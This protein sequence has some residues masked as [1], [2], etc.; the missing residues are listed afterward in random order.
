M[1]GAPKGWAPDVVRCRR[2]GCAVEFTQKTPRHAYC[3]ERCRWQHKDARDPERKAR[4]RERCAEWYERK[5][6]ATAQR[7]TEQPWLVGPPPFGEHLPGGAFSVSF[8]PP[9]RWPLDLRNAR[10]LH[11][12]MTTLTAIPHHETMPMFTLIPINGTR[13]KWGVWVADEGVAR[14]LAGRSWPGQVADQSVLIQCGPLVRFRAP[15]VERRGRQRVRVE[16][17]TPMT[18]RSMGGTVT[19]VNP[20]EANLLSTLSAWLP[21]RLG[22]HRLPLEFKLVEKRT[23]TVYTDLGGKFGRVAGFVGWFVADVNAPCRWL[24]EVAARGLGMGGRTAFGFGRIAV[25]SCE[26]AEERAA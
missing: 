16:I 10:L 8:T 12:I 3:S 18:I 23:E 6:A 25:S 13:G 19:R 4:N 22:L 7:R 1:I 15:T 14:R 20:T 24:L 17:L 26:A 5:R 11:G 2:P 21:R 9:P